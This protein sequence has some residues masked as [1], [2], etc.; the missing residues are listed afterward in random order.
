MFHR[1]AKF[2]LSQDVI[3]VFQ[4]DEDG[5]TE[6]TGI[7]GAHKL[8]GRVGTI[9]KVIKNPNGAYTYRVSYGG[10]LIHLYMENWL[11]EVEQ[12]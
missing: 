10:F 7:P 11:E 2:R 8:K 5:M 9:E 6:L 12:N 1:D 4:G 3:I